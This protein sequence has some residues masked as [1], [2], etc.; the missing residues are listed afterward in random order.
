MCFEMDGLQV[1][2]ADGLIEPELQVEG[3]IR[4]SADCT[5]D[6]LNRF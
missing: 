2:V 4:E 6:F 1:E 3:S 5:D